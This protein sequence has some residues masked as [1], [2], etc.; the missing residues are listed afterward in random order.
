MI[1]NIIL[2]WKNLFIILGYKKGDK[3]IIIIKI[4]KYVGFFIKLL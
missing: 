3:I 2:I 1:I 4:F